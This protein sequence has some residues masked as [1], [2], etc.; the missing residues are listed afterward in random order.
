MGFCSVRGVGWKVFGVVAAVVMA[1][2]VGSADGTGPDVWTGPL[3]HDTVWGPENSPYVVSGELVVEPAVTLTILPGVRV[4]FEQDAKMTVRGRLLAEATQAEPIRFSS[5]PG[6]G[7]PWDGLQFVDSNGPSRLCHAVVT[8]ASTNDGMVG[9]EHS[10][11]E[12]E[13]VVFDRCDRRRIR[14]LD[15]SLVLR[16]CIFT[17]MFG[18]NEPP[19]ADNLSEHIW[20]SG[21]LPGGQFVIEYCTFGR[22]VGHNDA[23][24]FDGPRLP[25]PIPQIRHNI[26][27][28]GGDDALDLECDAVIEYNV[29]TNYIKDRYNHASGEANVLSAG[30]GRY[31]VLVGNVFYNAQHVAQVKNDAFLSFINNTADQISSAAIYFELG[32]PGR[33]P[34]RGAAVKNCIFYRCPQVFAGVKPSTELTVDYSLISTDWHSYG[35]GNIDGDPCFVDPNGRDYH[36]LSQAGRWDTCSGNWVQDDLTSPCVDAGDPADPIGHEP[37]PSGG[38]INMGAYGGTAEASKSYFGEPVC[39]TIVAGDINGDCQVDLADFA[40]LAGHWL[41]N[42]RGR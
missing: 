9:L 34:G 15:S 36:L 3:I 2:G 17:D 13:D 10:V 18:P 42:G 19:S 4:Q 5:V 25:G 37:F 28:G 12:L 40:I 8:D 39:R 30:A 41:Q 21:I 31:Y 6:A 29:F 24:D 23:I 38:R 16:R 11:L 7:G 27:L 20:G 33:K 32:L 14:V 35:T 22:T 1:A 26:F